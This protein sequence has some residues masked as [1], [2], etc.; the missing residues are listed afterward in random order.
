MYGCYN[1]VECGA[2]PIEMVTHDEPLAV[3]ETRDEGEAGEVTCMDV[4][5]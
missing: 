4:N 3:G 2:V 1:V 5:P